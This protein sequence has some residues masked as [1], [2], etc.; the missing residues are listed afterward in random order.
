[1][2]KLSAYGR[3]EIGTVNKLISSKR[4]MSDGTVL[5]N[6]GFG[7][8]VFGKIKNGFTPEECFAKASANQ[9][10]VLSDNPDY[11]NYYRAL[12]KM[13]GLSKRWKLH[14]SISLMP[15]DCD[16][17]WSEVCDCYGDKVYADIDEIAAICRLYLAAMAAKNTRLAA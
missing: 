17:V 16:G 2:A 14:A 10:Q 9:A 1:M 13:A 12:H 8:K 6:K 5:E 15:E 7:W 11:A 4:Y 3:I